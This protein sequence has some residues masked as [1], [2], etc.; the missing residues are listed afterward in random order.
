MEKIIS[1]L[2]ENSPLLDRLGEKFQSLGLSELA[3]Q[4]YVRGGDVKKAIDSLLEERAT[5]LE[6]SISI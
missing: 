6:D 2:P 5:R 3:V 4:S 1:I